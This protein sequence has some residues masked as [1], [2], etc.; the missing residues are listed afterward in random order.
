[1]IDAERR[2]AIYEL[3]FC[4]MALA[5]EIAKATAHS[6]GRADASMTGC[7]PADRRSQRRE[8]DTGAADDV[9]SASQVTPRAHHQLRCG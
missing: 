9:N 5:D 8:S 6:L 1:M 2:S 7:S 4:L 3:G